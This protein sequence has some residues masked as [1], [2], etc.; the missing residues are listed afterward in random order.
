ML[1]LDSGL[2]AGVAFQGGRD[3]KAGCAFVDICGWSRVTLGEPRVEAGAAEWEMRV[4][5]W[6]KASKL[7]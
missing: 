4:D 2:G 5:G 3:A 6:G 1:F 7:R